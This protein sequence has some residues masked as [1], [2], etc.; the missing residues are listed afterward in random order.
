ML[1]FL[2]MP[3]KLSDN[4]HKTIHQKSIDDIVGSKYMYHTLTTWYALWCIFLMDR[5]GH[6]F[7]LN[8]TW[9]QRLWKAILGDFR[10]DVGKARWQPSYNLYQ[11]VWLGVTVIYW[12]PAVW[13]GKGLTVKKLND[14]GCS[15]QSI[16]FQLNNEQIKL[17]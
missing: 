12:R 1:L 2:C 11:T 14:C 3:D 10:A 9:A 6:S 7:W 17:K 8:N 5:D 15:V 16:K 4:Q 13:R